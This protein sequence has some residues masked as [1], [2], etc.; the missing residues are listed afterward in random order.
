MRLPKTIVKAFVL[1]LTAA[2]SAS[3]QV[4]AKTA[5]HEFRDALGD[6]LHIW[7]SP[8]QADSRDWISTV[9]VLAGGAALLPVDDQIDSWIVRHPNAAVVRATTP[10]DEDHPTLGDL[11]TSQRLIPISS[12]LLVSGMISDNRKLRE[13]GW[14][15]LSASQS[16][17]SIRG[18]LYDVVSRERPSIAEGNQYAFKTPGGDWNHHAFFAG[19]AANAWS[20][21]SFWTSRYHLS[22]LEPVLYAGAAGITFSR[23]KDR[24]HW[25]SDTWIGSVAG[26]A[27]GKSVAARYARRDA[28]REQKKEPEPIKAALLDGIQ[29]APMPDGGLALGWSGTFR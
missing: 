8:F 17:A 12:V 23:M 16:S 5:A 10:F 21:V 26:W 29:L 28:K 2:A 1:T 25:A 19:H 14:G 11:S 22:V 24:R 15:C 13:A 9:G 7:I 4:S 18:V 6:I 20:C 3:A 27:M